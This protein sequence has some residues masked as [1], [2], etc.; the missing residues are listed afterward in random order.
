MLVWA[1]TCGL[2]CYNS[3]M[4]ETT[5]STQA[6][7]KLQANVDYLPGITIAGAKDALLEWSADDRIKFFIMDPT[8]GVATE[9][10]FDV[11]VKEIERVTGGFNTLTLWVAGKPYNAQF[12]KTVALKLAIGGGIGLAAAY[13]DTKKSGVNDWLAAFRANGVNLKSVRDWSWV[14]KTSL[15]GFG[16][17]AVIAFIATVAVV[18][19][20]LNS[21]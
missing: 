5:P 6:P 9:V 16:V 3:A 19:V 11:S 10:L 14:V 1:T 21:N 2:V 4:N 20:S 18:V 15:I 7:A 17:C 12:S 8:A 13:R